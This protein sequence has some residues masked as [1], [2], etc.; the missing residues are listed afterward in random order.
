MTAFTRARGRE[1]RI[2][3][4]RGE[5]YGD[6]QSIEVYDF[7]T[8]E[9][10]VMDTDIASDGS[11]LSGHGGGDDGL[12]AA[13]LAAVGQNDPGLILSGPQETLESHLMVFAAERARQTGQVVDVNAAEP[14]DGPRSAASPLSD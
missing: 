4:T 3:G 9:T 14:R 11:I 5:L 6:S 10:S 12:M 8:G 1:T 7:L 13:F 2:F